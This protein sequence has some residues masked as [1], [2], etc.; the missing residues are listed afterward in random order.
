MYDYK[1]NQEK[2]KAGK[3]LFKILTPI[4]EG[5]SKLGCSDEDL[6]G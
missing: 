4:Y 5:L 3:E 6:L 1:D 2:L